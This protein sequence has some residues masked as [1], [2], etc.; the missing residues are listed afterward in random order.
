M[1]WIHV[2]HPEIYSPISPTLSPQTLPPNL[3]LSPPLAP[4]SYYILPSL[5]GW[6]S[7]IRHV[8]RR[9]IW[10]SSRGKLGVAIEWCYVRPHLCTG[11]AVTLVSSPFC[12]QDSSSLQGAV[13]GVTAHEHRCTPR[14]ETPSTSQRGVT[15]DAPPSPP[16]VPDVAWNMLEIMQHLCC[17]REKKFKLSAQHDKPCSTSPLCTLP[18]P[19]PSKNL[20]SGSKHRG[21]SRSCSQHLTA[22][23]L[24]SNKHQIEFHSKC[25]SGSGVVGSYWL[26]ICVFALFSPHAVGIYK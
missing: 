7:H 26:C 5:W 1:H 11:P 13:S 2:V 19:P 25:I 12:T 3:S 14:Y 20:Y 24:A 18:P 21:N 4:S 22:S 15:K 17:R 10:A 8:I 23:K 6:Q 9:E 16:L